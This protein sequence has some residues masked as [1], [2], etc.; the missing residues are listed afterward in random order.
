[1]RGRE[2]ARQAH[3]LSICGYFNYQNVG[4]AIVAVAVVVALVA[5]AA[6]KTLN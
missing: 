2:T 5:A 6:G 4:N 3:L 1:M